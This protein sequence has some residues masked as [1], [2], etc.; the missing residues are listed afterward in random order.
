MSSHS[1]APFNKAIPISGATRDAMEK[2][3]GSDKIAPNRAGFDTSAPVLR[4]PGWIRVRLPQGNAMQQLKARLRENGL[5]TV[6]EEATCPNI[7]ECFDKGTA[8]FMILGEV[9]TRRCSFC[10]IAHGRPAAPDPMEPKRLADTIRDM[11]LKYVVI[12]SVDRDDL[13][14]GGAE[15]FAACIGAVRRANAHVRIEIL[16]PDFRG[17]GRVERALDAVRCRLREW[18]RLSIAVW[19]EQLPGYMPNGRVLF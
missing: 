5:V 10:D 8:T 7:H 17:K 15:H 2:Q 13:R 11:Q 12:T 6:C 14:D 18:F 16:T 3:L 9:C 19:L 1:S 4:K